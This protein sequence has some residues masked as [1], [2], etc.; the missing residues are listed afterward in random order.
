[1]IVNARSNGKNIHTA[2]I[3]EIK[4]VASNGA[5]LYE[6]SNCFDW[7]SVSNWRASETELAAGC[8]IGHPVD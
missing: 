2:T 3:V 4:I 8:L 5:S 6:T 7:V 1:M